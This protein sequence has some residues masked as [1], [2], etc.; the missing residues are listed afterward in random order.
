MAPVDRLVDGGVDP[1]Q[2]FGG[3]SYLDTGRAALLTGH[4]T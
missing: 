4:H 2:R 1:G 3:A